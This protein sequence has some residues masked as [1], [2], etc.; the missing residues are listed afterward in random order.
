[1]NRPTVGNTQ[2]FNQWVLRALV[3]GVK[4]PGHEADHTL[5]SSAENKN[6]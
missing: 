5:S 4:R 3:L 1:V 6:V 2:P